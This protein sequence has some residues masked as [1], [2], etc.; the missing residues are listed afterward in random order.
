MFGLPFLFLPW[1]LGSGSGQ[2]Q[3]CRPVFNFQNP[4]NPLALHQP[5]NEML[6][7]IFY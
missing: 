5:L 3:E 4:A 6:N 1:S 7:E 2:K